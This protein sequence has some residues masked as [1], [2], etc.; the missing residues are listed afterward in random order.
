MEKLSKEEKKIIQERTDEIIKT[1]RP[2]VME[3]IANKRADLIEEIKRRKKELGIA[4]LPQPVYAEIISRGTGVSNFIYTAEDIGIL[5]EWY[6]KANAVLASEI[7]KHVVTKKQF[8]QMIGISSKQ[9]DE[10][11]H[12]EDPQ[13]SDV[14]QKVED[15]ITDTTQSM[16]M[17]Y[18][19]DPKV[20]MQVLKAQHG[21]YVEKKETTVTHKS[22]TIDA[23]KAKRFLDSVT[24]ASVIDVEID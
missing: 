15:Y 18:L 21:D 6:K 5:F 7:Q 22:D 23:D 8:C 13:M 10:Y 3:I 11:L 19:T 12:S 20:A 4:S 17:K 16:A 24:D 14:M 1:E 2:Q 9:Y